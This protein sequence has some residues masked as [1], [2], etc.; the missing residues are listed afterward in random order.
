MPETVCFSIEGPRTQGTFWSW[1]TGTVGHPTGS[2]F[3]WWAL[4]LT[5]KPHKSFTT[6]QMIQTKG[7]DAGPVTS[8]QA[9]QKP[10]VGQTIQFSRS[11][12]QCSPPPSLSPRDPLTFGPAPTLIG[13]SKSLNMWLS[14]FITFFLMPSQTL[15]SYWSP[16]VPKQLCHQMHP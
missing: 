3:N 9:M 13:N 7:A 8:L 4:P 11:G 6:R 12:T 1:K 16:W 2:L 5:A 15:G 14:S 10:T